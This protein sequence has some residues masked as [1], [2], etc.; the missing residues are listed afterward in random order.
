MRSRMLLVLLTTTIVSA[1]AV[2]AQIEVPRQSPS[3]SVT[4]TIGTTKIT[5]DYH[6]PGVKGRTIWGGLVPYD[7]PWRMGA[8]EATTI[9]FSDPVRIA[10]TEVPAGKY[11]LFAVPKRDK[12][13]LILNKDPNQWG[14][15]GY[16]ATKD[17]V[18]VDVAPV[19]APHTEWMRFTVDPVTPSSAV[20]TLNWE[21]VAI[22]LNIDVDVAK[23]VW[24][25]IDKGL[26]SAYSAAANFA[27][28]RGERLEEG[29]R[30]IDQSIAA[31]ESPFNLWTKARLLQKLGRAGEAVPLM[32]RALT[33]ARDAK[34]PADFMAILEGSMKSIQA[35][36][37]KARR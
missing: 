11:S 23:I 21:N 36:A 1:S 9:T 24:S 25:D 32:E 34:M 13:T 16:D 6:R 7:A 31:G 37:A 19:A 3:A 29:L 5:V 30:W 22:P 14:A 20:V 15:Y 12:W 17:L 2:L 28:D 10:G 8:N 26:A 27:L 4:Q 35:D 18:R 33:R